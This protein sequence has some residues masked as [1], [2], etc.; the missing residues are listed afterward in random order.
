MCVMGKIGVVFG[1]P[2]F[3]VICLLLWSLPTEYEQWR[4]TLPWFL[5]FCI[6]PCREDVLVSA[7]M[8]R[9]SA[10]C[11]PLVFGFALLLNSL[12]QRLVAQRSAVVPLLIAPVPESRERLRMASACV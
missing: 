9:T 4:K 10:A 8:R 6:G 11:V 1:L 7:A 5:A 2:H 3:G 12:R